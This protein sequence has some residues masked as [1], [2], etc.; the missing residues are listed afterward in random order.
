MEIFKFDSKTNFYYTFVPTGYT[1][2]N[3][4]PEYKKI[5]AKSVRSLEE[6]IKSFGGKN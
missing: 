1:N 3:G 5:R 4:M 6:K 2:S